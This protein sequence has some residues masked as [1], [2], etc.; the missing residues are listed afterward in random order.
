[1]APHYHLSR[2][3]LLLSLLCDSLSALALLPGVFFKTVA[4]HPRQVNAAWL[5]CEHPPAKSENASN[6]AAQQ[7][8]LALAVAVP[9]S[10]FLYDE[11]RLRASAG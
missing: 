8:V 3:P 11:D 1:M 2:V 10:E 6:P 4:S 5:P 9:T 7:Y